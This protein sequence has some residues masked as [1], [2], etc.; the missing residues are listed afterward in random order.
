[1]TTEYRLEKN[2]YAVRASD[3]L[4]IPP[5]PLNGDR[6]I[7]QAW[8]DAG[9][10]PVPYVPPP[11]PPLSFFARDLIEALMPDDL[12]AIETAVA[13]SAP[14]RLLWLRLRTREGKPVIAEGDAF[15]KGWAGLMASLG[16]D[17][18]AEISAKLKL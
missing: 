7:Y 1:M 10:I 12:V 17:R 6:I 3:G 16:E 5:D 14:L 13:G 9:G 18:V 8:L 4:Y 15:A 2:G 11:P